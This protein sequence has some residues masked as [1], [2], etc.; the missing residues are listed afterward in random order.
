MAMVLVGVFRTRLYL[1]LFVVFGLVA[2]ACGN[3]SNEG[4]PPSERSA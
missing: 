4:A 3:A 2:V 1:P